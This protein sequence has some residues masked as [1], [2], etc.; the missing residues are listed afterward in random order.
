MP[1]ILVAFLL[2]AAAQGASLTVSLSVTATVTSSAS[3]GYAATGTANLTGGITDHGTFSATIPLSAVTSTTVNASYT[4]G[5]SMGTMTGTVAI[6]VAVLLG[7]SSSASGTLAVTGGA[8]NYAGDTGSFN[9]SGSGG[10][11]PS[12]AISIMF[13]GSGT[14]TT[15]GTTAPSGPTIT[16]VLDAGSYTANV[17]EGSIFVVKGSNLSAG[18]FSEATAPYPNSLGTASITF[19]PTSGGTGSQA[20]MIYTY[21]QNGVNQLAGVLPSTVAAGSYNV[22]VAYNGTASA[23]FVTQVVKAKPALLTQDST[24]S[25]LALLQNYISA[26]QYD[27]NR[28]TTGTVNGA[29]I[30]PAKPGQTVVAWGTGLGPVP[31]PDNSPPS[32]GYT[33]SNVTVLVGG[34][35]ITP[36]YAGISAYPGFDQ[37]NFTLPT[38][39]PTGCAV[40]LQV[41]V[42]NVKSAVTTISIAPNPSASACV[43]PGLTQQQLQQLDNGGTY[44]VGYFGLA[45]FAENISGSNGA[46]TSISGS[47]SQITGFELG[48]IPAAASVASNP[49]GACNVIQVTVTPSGATTRGV[50]KFLDAGKVTVNGPAGSNL[51]NIAVTET[52]NLYSAIL[53]ETAGSGVPGLP[54]GMLVPGTYTLAGAGGQDVSSFTTS[55]TLGAPLTIAGGLPAT[56]TE[57][58]GLPLSW[59]GGNASDLVEIIGYSG[60]MTGTAA[61]ALTSAAEFICTTTAGAAGFTVPPSI[62]TQLPTSSSITSGTAAGFL[63]VISGPSPVTFSPSLTAGGTAP[64]TFSA[65]VGSAS[66]V[67]Y[68]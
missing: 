65:L 51:S 7:S 41:Q 63:E 56:V 29:T 27:V 9:V 10:L 55:I 68:Q 45:Q 48:S 6:P 53:G 3:G 66:A 19:T 34:T 30:S 39:V 58:A 24:G 46:F 38:N 57:S 33:Y 16:A 2:C 18:G 8:G 14:I 64:S 5:L 20:L 13:S 52:G 31:F 25:G 42:G 22:T 61:N 59:T 21:S 54:N 60:S 23:P 11:T 36:A 50:A 47:F 32:S 1:K 15:T 12:G 67:S 43:Y 44:T 49:A 28:L 4:M 35:A 62:L 26:T 17:A 40:S 37:I